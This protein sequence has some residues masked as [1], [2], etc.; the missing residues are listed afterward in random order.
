MKKLFC[1]LFLVSIVFSLTTHRISKGYQTE[2]STLNSGDS[3]LSTLGLFKATLVSSSCG[4]SIDVFNNSTNK[5]DNKGVYTYD[6][7]ISNS[8]YDTEKMFYLKIRF[9]WM[10]PK[11]KHFQKL[12]N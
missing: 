4:L 7:A 11:Q 5:Y 8:N 9:I 6:V 2:I 1:E 3:I 10:K 12:L